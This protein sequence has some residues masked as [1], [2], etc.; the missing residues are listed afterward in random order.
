M[1]NQLLDEYKLYYS[2]RAEKYSNNPNYQNSYEAEKKLSDAM[3]SCSELEEFKTK[4]GDLNEKCA[5][6]L[7]KDESIMEKNHFLKHKEIVRAKASERILDQI[8]GIKNVMDAITLVSEEN[9]KNS[10]EIISDE[11]HRSFQSEWKHI[12]EIRIYKNA[13]VPDEYKEYMQTSVSDM[14][15]SMVKRNEDLEKET[16]DWQSGWK[17]KP[18]INTE[19]R[20]R[21]LIPYEDEHMN[22]QITFYKS[23]INR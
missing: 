15:Q 18:E 6:A 21:R 16:Q 2:V 22:E 14:R 12:D 9:N 3:Q 7:I 1:S 8:D 4:I 11:N 20:H 13:V 5:T 17:N 19:H 23:I 10:I